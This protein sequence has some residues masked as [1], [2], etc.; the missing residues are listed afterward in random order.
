MLAEKLNWNG[1]WSGGSL[2]D[3]SCV[4]VQA[5]EDDFVIGKKIRPS[6]LPIGP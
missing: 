5:D 6:L 4:F 3:G 1:V 2:P